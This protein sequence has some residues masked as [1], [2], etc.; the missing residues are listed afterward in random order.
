MNKLSPIYALLTAIALITAASCSSTS[1]ES[2][3]P[4]YISSNTLVSNFSLAKNDSVMALLDSVK[5]SIDVDKHVIYNADSLPK[6]TKI[7]RLIANITFASS[8]SSGEISISGAST[9]PDTTFTYTSSDADSIDFTG[10]VYLTVNAADGYNSSR[11]ELKVNVHQ[12]EP[13]TLYWNRLARRS[14][15]GSSQEPDAQKTAAQGSTVYCL[16]HDR[17]GY[18]LSTTDDIESNQWDIEPVNFGFTPDISSFSTTGNALYILSD[19]GALYSSADRG[20][21][22]TD[23]GKTFR[24]I[25]GGYGD[26]L[27]GISEENGTFYHE[28][29]P[30]SVKTQTDSDFPITGMSQA[31]SYTSQWGTS[32][33][34]FIVG[35]VKADGSLTG[36]TWGFDG[37]SWAEI[38]DKPI[39]ARSGMT[40]IPYY[41]HIAES[42]VYNKYPVLL[43]VG[44]RDSGGNALKD[45]YISYDNGVNWKLG[46]ENLQ[47]PDYMPAFYGAQALVATTTLY[48]ETRSS[49]QWTALASKPLPV[50]LTAE[51]PG[52]PATRASRP[53]T[54]WECP[55][56][57]VFGGYASNGTLQNNIWKGVINRLT[58]K[59]II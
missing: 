28:T 22:W 34:L 36:A 39:P 56:I 10:R 23:T 44:G 16:T 25:V 19:A 49:G 53:V 15:P 9:M 38:S 26:T 48:A 17:S 21:T 13:D 50:W 31:C 2:D 47:L 40:L 29:Y 20:A 42:T 59:P 5:F 7:T 3:E 30:S 43:A 18:T 6:G 14:L 37:Q 46:D 12:M 41:N 55:Y 45:V 57:Y 58:F 24:T 51:S 27:L 33:Q 32:E 54:S 11:Y 1:D 8:T 4:V 35:G 52:Q